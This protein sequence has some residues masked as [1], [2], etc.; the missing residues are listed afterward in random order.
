MRKLIILT[1]L[2]AAVA[3]AQ[4]EINWWVFDGGGG[5]RSPASGDTVWASIGQPIIGCR[6]ESSTELCAGYLCLFEGSCVKI[7]EKPDENH[8]GE[9]GDDVKRP[10]VFGINSTAPNPFNP[11]CRIEFEVESDT[12]V[13]FEFYDILGRIV[14][15]PIR[16]ESMTPGRYELTWGGDLPSGTY[17]A[18]LSSGDKSTVKQIVYLK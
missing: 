10:F 6:V 13:T 16:G 1:L 14:D 7:E 2:L 18:R 12:P 3:F 11:T 15:T 4:T 5:M 8:P 17:F 9:D